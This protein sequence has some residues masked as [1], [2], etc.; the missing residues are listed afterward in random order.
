MLA[1]MLT[2]YLLQNNVPVSREPTYY[3]T[4]ELCRSA[5]EEI[6]QRFPT[7]YGVCK[8]VQKD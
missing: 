2:L 5:A 4:E 6:Q 8:R 7:Y 3:A 1:W